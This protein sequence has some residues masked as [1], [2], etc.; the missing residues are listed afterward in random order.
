M[1]LAIL[2]IALV[3]ADALTSLAETQLYTDEIV[4]AKSST[5]RPPSHA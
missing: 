1:M 5:P 4:Y 3:K 2:G